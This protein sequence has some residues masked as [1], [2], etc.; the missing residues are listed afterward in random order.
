V[1]F[2]DITAH[3]R[4]EGQLFTADGLHPAAAQYSFWA[5][6]LADRIAQHLS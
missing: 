2:I 3:S 5:R 4:S 1:V 6:Q